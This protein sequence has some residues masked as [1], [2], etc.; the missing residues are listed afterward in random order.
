VKGRLDG[1]IAAG[2]EAL[3]VGDQAGI[4]SALN[5]LNAAYS[6]AGA[7]L[8]EAANAAGSA[9]STGTE[10]SASQADGSGGQAKE[11]VVEADYEIVDEEKK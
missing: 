4:K 6:A 11:D 9:G 10:G 2:R 1:A 7:S 5:E 3:R 8:Y